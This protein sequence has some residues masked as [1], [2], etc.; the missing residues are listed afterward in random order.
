MLSNYYRD[1]HPIFLLGGAYL[2]LSFCAQ[3]VTFV[4][5]LSMEWFPGFA[6]MSP[7]R[8]QQ[9]ADTR[10]GM[11]ETGRRGAKGAKSRSRDLRSKTSS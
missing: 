6:C 10:D 3:Y 1:V 5:W 8:A 7:A 9:G 11:E 4:F 2:S